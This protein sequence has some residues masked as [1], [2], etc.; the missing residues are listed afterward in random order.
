M[1]RTDG[2]HREHDVEPYMEILWL[3]LVLAQV[4]DVSCVQVDNSEN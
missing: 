3:L 4:I 1:G 2:V